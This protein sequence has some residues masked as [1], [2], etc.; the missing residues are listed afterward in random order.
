MPKLTTF[1]FTL[2]SSILVFAQPANDDCADAT[3]LCPNQVYSATTTDATADP[4]SDNNFCFT[5]AATVWFYFTT[6]ADG[7]DVSVDITGLTF[8]PDPT[9]G[10]TIGAI[11]YEATTPCDQA[12]YTPYAMCGAGSTD[13]SITNVVALA[14]NTTYYVQV[15]GRIVGAGVT[16]PAACDFNIEISGTAVDKPIP[17]VTIADTV[18]DICTGDEGTV[19]VTITGCSDTVNYE[20]LYG[21][22]TLTSGATD[23]F[24]KSLIS[25]SGDLELVI[26]C[27]TLCPQVDTSN[28]I[29]YTV[30]EISADAG[31]DQFITKGDQVTIEGDGIGTPLWSP[32]TTLT[33]PNIYQ[34][35]AF[36]ESTTI[37]FLTVTEGPCVRTDSVTVNVGEL[38]TIYSSFTPNGDDVNDKWIITNSGSFPNMEV[39]VYDRSGQ[40]VFNTVNYST[41]EKWWDG[42]FKGKELP[43]STYFYVIDLKQG[44]EGIFK[45]PV[46]I[47]R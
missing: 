28:A 12:T 41:P 5:P 2:T 46:T 8:D 14:G 34:P 25:A 18:T 35:V 43:S 4:V 47:I 45:G 36:P 1:F 29:T 44:D 32:S 38:I 40:V 15:N 27:G 6:D 17:T 19:D 30:T 3:E 33:D 20:W 31:P 26:T 24:N 11:F 10:Q 42:T 16:D 23:D 22:T 9:K 37:Y 13:M 21:G 39:T 7:G